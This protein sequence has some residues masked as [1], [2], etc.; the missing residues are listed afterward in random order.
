LPDQFVAVLMPSEMADT[1][2]FQLWLQ[3]FASQ[4]PAKLRVMVMDDVKAPQLKRLVDA[5]PIRVVAKPLDLDMPGARLEISQQAGGLDTPGGQYRHLFV[6]LSNALGEGNLAQALAFGQA[7]L[8]I[9]QAQKWFALATP[10]QFSLGAAL[11]G[12][13][14]TTEANERYLQA[15]IA[16]TEGE[17]AG[18]PVCT[19]L[20][21]QARMARGALLISMKQF[22]MAAELFLET[23]PLATKAED[24]RMVLDCY[25]LASFSYEQAGQYEKAWNTGVDG[26]GYAKTLEDET[27][28]TSNLPY[29]GEGMLRLA[30]RP[31]YKGAEFTVDREMVGLLGTKD[32]RPK[33]AAPPPAPSP[34]PNS[35]GGSA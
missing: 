18:D 12:N 1:E 16:A 24:P 20:R 9:A 19:K 7:A 33:T 25:R 3:R 28:K 8:G 23:I 22:P 11:A 4:A 27:R 14:Q 30:K 34:Q 21:P 10:I 5:E 2:A 17:T 32:W 26:I 15:E 29:L 31:E 35:P 6:K 13:G